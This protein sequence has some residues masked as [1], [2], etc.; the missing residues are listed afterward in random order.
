MKKNT[1]YIIIAA[2]AGLLLGYVLFSGTNAVEKKEEHLHSK[3]EQMWTCS[4]HPQI[5]RPEPGDC[6]ICGMDLI[7]AGHQDK[8][9]INVNRFSMTKNAMALANIQTTIVGNITAKANTISL[10]GKI[11]PNEDETFTQPAHFNGRIEK[12]YV[13]SVGE[14]VNKGQAIAVLYSPELISAQQEL[15]TAYKMKESQP[16]LYTAVRNK[17]KN[18]MIPEK[19]INEIVSSGKVKNR[20]TIYSHISGVV[21]N[22]EATE[23]SHIM[24]GKAIFTTANLNSVWAVFDAYETQIPN[25]KKGQKIQITT[26]AYPS[27]TI[28][29]TI[30]YID[31]ILNTETRTVEVRA[32][33][34]N[35]DSALKPGMFVQAT[36]QNVGTESNMEISIPASAVMWTG[37]RSVVYVKDTA[38]TPTFEMRRIEIGSKNG[39][40]YTV[41]NGLQ[42]GEEVVTQGTFTV[43]AAAQLQGKASMM[44]GE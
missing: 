24:D 5:M 2:I 7:P 11:Q 36:L 16:G 18:W 26:N 22:L 14:T 25:I 10:S 43:D 17:F 19:E 37:K 39:E 23:G 32:V 38:G 9:S 1:I 8:D 31:P 44:N 21:T 33:L 20:F 41:I 27:K 13:K 4:M 34:K 30:N 35:Q 28:N 12:L 3:N 15:L 40:Y 42:N 6:P 29:A